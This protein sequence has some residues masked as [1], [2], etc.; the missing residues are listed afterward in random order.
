MLKK[1]WEQKKK[2]IWIDI[3]EKEDDESKSE[4][5][6]EDEDQ[7][8]E[9]SESSDEDEAPVEATP[10]PADGDEIPLW[11]QLVEFFSLG[12]RAEIDPDLQ[13]YQASCLEPLRSCCKEEAD[14]YQELTDIDKGE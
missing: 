7:T 1:N 5:E 4:A 6:E 14:D 13:E 8:E 3:I 2:K 9:S 11:K 10:R 12:S